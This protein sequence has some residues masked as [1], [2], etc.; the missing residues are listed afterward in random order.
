MMLVGCVMMVI[1]TAVA[2]FGMTLFHSSNAR[3]T[4]VVG[5]GAVLLVVGLALYLT[6]CAAA[7]WENG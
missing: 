5:G 3:W 1:G 4:Y 7:W 2:A 6:A